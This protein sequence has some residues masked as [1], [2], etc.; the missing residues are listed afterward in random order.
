MLFV[1]LMDFDVLLH[2]QSFE[3]G[4][5]SFQLW[6]QAYFRGTCCML[7]HWSSW[8]WKMGPSNIIAFCTWIMFPMNLDW[9]W[10]KR[11]MNEYTCCVT[12]VGLHRYKSS[13]CRWLGTRGGLF[14]QMLQEDINPTVWLGRCCWF[15][16]MFFC[17]TD[18]WSLAAIWLR[19]TEYH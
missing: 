7:F 13:Y 18:T 10:G 1:N 15:F 9:L 8:E 2:D 5:C 17:R 11:Y 12:V 3:H 16:N 19:F 6:F 14:S 4:R